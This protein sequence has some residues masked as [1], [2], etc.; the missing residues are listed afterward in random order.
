MTNKSLVPKSLVWIGM[1]QLNDEVLEVVTHIQFVA[2]WHSFVKSL[3]EDIVTARIRKQHVVRIDWQ[4]CLK[5][6]FASVDK[7]QSDT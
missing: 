5:R 3:P 2:L 6:F 1:Q 4:G 7:E